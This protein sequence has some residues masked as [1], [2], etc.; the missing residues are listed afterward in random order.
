[1]NLTDRVDL[2]CHTYY[3]DGELSPQAVAEEAKRVGLR[4]VAITDHDTMEGLSELTPV[5][6]LEIVPG[7]ERKAEWGGDEIHILGYDCDWDILRRS[8]YLERDR[9]ERNEALIAKLRADGIDVSM[10]ELMSLKKGIVGRPHI[11]LLLVKKGY[12]STVREAFDTWLGNGRPY[13]VPITRRTVPEV[14]EELRR[15]GAKIVLAHPL[16][17]EFSE[18]YHLEELVE[19]CADS[20]FHG[21]EIYYSNYTEEQSAFLGKLAARFDLCPTAGSD[22]HGS[23]RPDRVVGGA[24]GPYALLEALRAKER[25]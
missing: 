14:A 1:M 12:F 20:G 9:N 18:G 10:E 4:A 2:H 6:G 5:P 24:A 16:Q 11:A 23:R 15:A 8:P 3:S 25:P 7:I 22:F 21:M 17:Y 19:L 13:Y